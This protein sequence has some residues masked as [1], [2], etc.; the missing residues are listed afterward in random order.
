MARELNDT[1]NSGYEEKQTETETANTGPM[2]NC[3][4]K[5]LVRCYPRNLYL[6]KGH[7]ASEEVVLLPHVIDLKLHSSSEHSGFK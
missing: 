6:G 4:G 1:E 5:S 2:K 7:V 3:V